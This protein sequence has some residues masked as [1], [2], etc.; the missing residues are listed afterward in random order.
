MFGRQLDAVH[1]SGRSD[2][3]IL[4]AGEASGHGPASQRARV[5]G[6]VIG[7]P[8]GWRAA[9]CCARGCAG[10]KSQVAFRS[11]GGTAVRRPGARRGGCAGPFSLRV[12]RADLRP[13]PGTARSCISPGTGA[14]L[15]HARVCRRDRR[16]LVPVGGGLAG[17]AGRRVRTTRRRAWV[18]GADGAGPFV[19]ML[20]RAA[21][22]RRGA[23][24]PGSAAGSGH[25]RA[26]AA[27][28]A[29][30]AGTGRA[31]CSRGGVP[32]WQQRRHRARPG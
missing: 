28:A 10:S 18:R 20:A 31:W 23:C 17:A 26:A 30:S 15:L 3:G 1:G 32:S 22:A 7:G 16:R 6:G 29:Q 21:Q 14:Q 4:C 27:G 2:L 9:I 8:A 25:E 11:R 5:A 19:F 24:L 13:D 12:S